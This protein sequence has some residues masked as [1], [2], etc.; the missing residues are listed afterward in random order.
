MPIRRSITDPKGFARRV[1]KLREDRGMTLAELGGDLSHISQTVVEKFFTMIIAADFPEA[2]R[3]VT[4]WIGWYNA[5]RPHQALGYR[6]P[7]EYEATI[8]QETAARA[9]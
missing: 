1:A 8:H 6:S 5:E 7:A 3:A 9:A 2:R 4:A